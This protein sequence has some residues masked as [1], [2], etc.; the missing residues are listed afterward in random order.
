MGNFTTRSI[1]RAIV[2]PFQFIALGFRIRGR[3][4]LRELGRSGAVS[5]CNHIHMVDC[6]MVDEA[7]YDRRMYYLTLED[8]FKI[9]VVRE[10]IR[11]LGAVPI[12]R[13]PGK[14]S[15]L[16]SEMSKA[17]RSGSFVQVYPEGTLRPYCT[18]L[19]SFRDGAFKLA[20]DSG[21]PIVPAVL[22]LRAR[23]GLYRLYKRKAC[24]SLHIMPPMYPDTALPTRKEAIE[25]LRDRCKAAMEETLSKYSE[26]PAA[27]G[28]DK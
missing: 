8:S 22:T 15:E 11:G 6:T 28:G 14:M 4:N 24:L 3:E 23:R 2:V 9:P 12:P 5:I 19:R 10:L 1:V 25:E 18:K 7:F 13:T 27:N 20:V 26:I 21:A 16:F 17:V